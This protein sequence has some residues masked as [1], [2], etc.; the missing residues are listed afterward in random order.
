MKTSWL[1]SPLVAS[2]TLF[3]GDA[4]GEDPS[5]APLKP[6]LTKSGGGDQGGGGI[7]LGRV[8]LCGVQ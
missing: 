6:P 5:T 3:G 4:R 2:W 7:N 1:G 8:S